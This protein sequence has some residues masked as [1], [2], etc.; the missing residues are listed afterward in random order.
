MEKCY[1]KTIPSVGDRTL[2]RKLL[3]DMVNGN[4]V[5]NNPGLM[6]ITGHLACI[7]Q[8]T[9]LSMVSIRILIILLFDK[10]VKRLLDSSITETGDNENAVDYRCQF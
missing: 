1:S 4:K 7:G 10:V 3:E 8:F 5:V 6:D 2:M 9:I